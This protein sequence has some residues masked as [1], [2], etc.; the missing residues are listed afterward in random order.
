MVD[1][2]RVATKRDHRL[3][4]IMCGFGSMIGLRIA[5]AREF[6][7]S[8]AQG[9]GHINDGR[10]SGLRQFDEPRL[11]GRFGDLYI[12]KRKGFLRELL[13]VFVAF[14]SDQDDVA[15][16]RQCN[17][18]INRQFT[19]DDG[20][21]VTPLEPL[22][23]VADDRGRIFA[24]GVVGRDDRIITALLGHLPHQ[25]AFG[26]VT[27]STA[28]ENH[29]QSVGIGLSEGSND[30]AERVISVS[31]IHVNLVVAFCRYKLQTPRYRRSRGKRK[32]GSA[33]LN[34]D[35]GRGGAGRP[36]GV[37]T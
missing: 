30:V 10:G 11:D 3:P 12:V 27:I 29:D 17:G 36:G 1:P 28:P 20:F 37:S 16:L 19:I 23:N 24:S 25:G 34:A 5:R 13:I 14:A 7:Y 9:G 15:W 26:T 21:V 31:I 18:S 4:Q 2:R 6:A 22:L 33:E 35:G 8:A 32:D